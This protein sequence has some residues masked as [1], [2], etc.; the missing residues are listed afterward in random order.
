VRC[1]VKT[2]LFDNL[3]QDGEERERKRER[4]TGKFFP[5]SIKWILSPVKNTWLNRTGF[6]QF[7]RIS[8]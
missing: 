1:Q 7:K 4:E 8:G 2:W 6:V 3:T 5:L